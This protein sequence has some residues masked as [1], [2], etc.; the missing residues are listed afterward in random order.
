M[1]PSKAT[2]RRA[3]LPINRG[4]ESW[5]NRIPDAERR[6]F[7]IGIPACGNEETGLQRRSSAME[8]EVDHLGN[9]IAQQ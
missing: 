2:E 7:Q 3:F 5:N 6:S 9:K 4:S 1:T 8:I